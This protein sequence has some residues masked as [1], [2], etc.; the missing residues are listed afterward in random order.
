[1]FAEVNTASLRSL[2][3]SNLLLQM[4]KY[5]SN[6]VFQ[7]LPFKHVYEQSVRNPTNF[8][9]YLFYLIKSHNIWN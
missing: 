1:M 4:C 2:Q 9:N 5:K 3:S 8:A 7:L 6:Y